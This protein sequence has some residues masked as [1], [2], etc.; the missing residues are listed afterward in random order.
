[1]Q[2]KNFD[3]TTVPPQPTDEEPGT[4]TVSF[5]ED[6]TEPMGS[7]KTSARA[8]R[9]SGPSRSSGRLVSFR[10]SESRATSPQAEVALRNHSVMSCTDE[11]ERAAVDNDDE[12]LPTR[13]AAPPPQ[14][15]QAA[16]D[17]DKD[18]QTWPP[19]RE[20]R[21][22]MSLR[23]DPASARSAEA[24]VSVLH[25]VLT[26][27][28][29]SSPGG[30]FDT[31]M[32]SI[33][34]EHLVVTLRPGQFE[35][36][37]L[38]C[39]TDDA[40]EIFCFCQDQTARN[41]WVYVFRRVAGVQVRPLPRR[42]LRPLSLD[43]SS[44]VPSPISMLAMQSQHLSGAIDGPSHS[45]HVRAKFLEI[46][47]R[48]GRI[49]AATRQYVSEHNDLDACD[50]LEPD[51]NDVSDLLKAS[52]C[53]GSDHATTNSEGT[54]SEY[55]MY[56]ASGLEGDAMHERIGRKFELLEVVLES[57]EESESAFM[58]CA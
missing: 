7:R 44:A 25:N 24:L 52:T 10:E 49:S 38:S 22:F 53:T 17:D 14:H 51:S 35:L 5:E 11:E 2:P 1:L 47:S 46:Q 27:H 21:G 26:V 13:L 55:S 4:G 33:P 9:A 12:H 18:M 19:H 34:V 23:L 45:E 56:Y 39:L 54:Y 16:L 42:A 40:G 32:A 43:S 29:Q 31:T 30:A 37:V 58:R 36:L 3:M 48:R 28:I 15:D 20:A 41:K 57:I 8:L 6:C 50:A